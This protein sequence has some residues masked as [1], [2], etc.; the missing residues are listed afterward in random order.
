MMKKPI[1]TWLTLALSA[2]V[3]AVAAV[4]AAAQEYPNRP[5]RLIVPFG[6]GSGPDIASR[7]VAERMSASLKQ[8]VVVENRPGA[9][10]MLGTDLIA[11]AT[12]DGYTFG[13]SITG[14]LVNSTVIQDKMPYDPFKDL[15]PLS[16]GYLQGSV[17]AVSSNLNV[18]TAQELFALLKKN[19]GKYN[20]ASL[21]NGTVAHLSMELIKLKTSSFVVHIPYST[22]PAAVTSIVAGDT[23]MG[24]LPP[25]AVMPQA[26][27]GR[28]KALA[29]TT[30]ARSPQMPELPTF[31]EIGIPEVEATAW[32]GFVIS[33]KA[34]QAI[35]ER[36]N[37][38]IVAALKD[39]GVVEKLRAQFVD[40][41]PSTQ[42]EFAKF[43]QDELKRWTPVIKRAGVKPD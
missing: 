18:N 30:A 24:T 6:P 39:T 12:P 35:Q 1:S 17:L 33:S 28:L 42:A 37:R 41:A 38:E 15:A 26:R 5:L 40:A 19:P 22:S 7:L 16:L 10:G 2:L 14:P 31:R 13:M 8:A 43:M 20:F 23:H 32:A 36:L 21:G 25:A 27:A 9:G 29:V 34:P 11:K 3:S 4:P